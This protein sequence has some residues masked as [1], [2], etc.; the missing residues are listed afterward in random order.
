MGKAAASTSSKPRAPEVTPK[1]EV[2]NQAK[3]DKLINDAATKVGQT[4]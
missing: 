4:D 1:K 3:I 2:D